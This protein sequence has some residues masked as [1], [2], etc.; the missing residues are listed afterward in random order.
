MTA[1]PRRI[2]QYWSVRDVV[3]RVLDA[4]CIVAG[5]LVGL[6]LS[7]VPAGERHLMAAAAAVV[8][9]YLTAEISG[10]YRNWRGV[11]TEREVLCAA[12]TW[13]FTLLFLSATGFIV[14]YTGAF[15]LR[16]MIAWA[17][18]TPALVAMSRIA[19]RVAQRTLRSR[20]LNTR[21]YAIVG[22][23]EL[24]F[25]L[26]RNI[27]SSVE[28]GL[29]L[30]GFYDDRPGDRTPDVPTDIGHKVGDLEELI[31]HARRRKVDMI[32]ITFPMRAEDRIKA[33]LEK[34]G[35]TTASVYIVP[36]FFVFELMHSRWTSISGLPVVSVFENPFY[37]IDGVVKR[38]LDVVLAS[39]SLLVATVPMLMIA[40]LVKLSSP[41]PVLFR[42]KRYGLDGREISV[43]KFRTMRV[44]E[45]GARVAQ[46]TKNDPRVTKLGAF[47]RRS[48]LDEL[49]Q[50]FNVLEGT[51]SLVG[52]RPHANTHNEEYRKLIDRYML[53][54]KVKPGITGLAQVSG[55]RG[56]TDTLEK[57]EKRIACDHQ[58]IR[59]WSLWMD[60]K[61]LA[62]TFF[63]VTCGHNAY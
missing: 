3:H 45:N 10:M 1:N 44:C 59:E 4:A 56:E 23:N 43:W 25:Q 22:V 39:L 20:G 53:R 47:L 14:G 55:W 54:H 37:G 61:I 57:M 26:A 7:G 21:T 24:G 34:L 13:G 15:P 16:A 31:E 5:S 33:I 6:R 17:L 41:G 52:P 46:A 40:A 48:S 36:D 9:Y 49:P 63:V 27:D 51:M 19:I 28:L 38:S 2:Q 32:Y 12:F 42:Q 18:A 62:K 30:I 11:S 58:Y 50:F 8:L 35:D 29:R 60:I